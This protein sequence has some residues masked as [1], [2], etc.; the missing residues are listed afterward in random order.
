MPADGPPLGS[1][2]DAS[3]P[4]GSSQGSSPPAPPNPDQGSSGSSPP[5]QSSFPVLTTQQMNEFLLA[6]LARMITGQAQPAGSASTNPVATLFPI[7]PPVVPTAP[8][9]TAPTPTDTG[10]SIFSVFYRIESSL[11]QAVITHNLQPLDIY[12]LQSGLSR[13]GSAKDRYPDLASV[14]TPLRTYFRILITHAESGSSRAVIAQ[15]ARG[16]IDYEEH[17]TQLSRQYQWNA[18]LRYHEEYH[19]IRRFDML[20]R[21]N[22]SSWGP[23]DTTLLGTILVAH[24]PL[25]S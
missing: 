11:V 7:A 23:P 24:P 9:F 2:G 25:R 12:K 15:L 19:L 16:A 13:E 3:N 20:E 6:V 22:Y 5:Q 21:S 17:L 4:A 10:E 1:A 18:V 14:L 8:P